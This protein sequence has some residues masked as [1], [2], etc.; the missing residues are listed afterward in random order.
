MSR[1]ATALLVASRLFAAPFQDART[2]E[3]AGPVRARV[4]SE[5]ARDLYQQTE[6]QSSLN[7][8]LPLGKKDAGGFLLIG[9]DYF[10]L[11]DYKKSTDAFDRALALGNGSQQLYVWA[12]RAYG[13]RAE[14]SGPFTA[15]GLA[16]RARKYFEAA[17]QMDIL[18]K[19][20]SGD[21]FDYYMG[22]PGFLGGGLNKAQELARR[23]A[24]AD[25]AEGQHL[26]AA[27]SDKS[28]EYDAEEQH[29]RSAIQLAPKQAGRVMELARFLAQRGRAKESD[30]LFD[31]A[32]RMAPQSHSILFYR[33]LA[34]IEGNRNLSDARAL[35]RAYLR[36]PLTPDD[37]PRQ[38]AQELLAKTH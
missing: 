6:Y 2:T 33:A 35:L 27:L 20:A 32:E 13:R 16:S 34:Y 26:L 9:Q 24:A 3:P 18:N 23:V 22:A 31:Q 10:M 7:L 28:K 8:L 4:E 15:P 30:A 19:E 29:L 21:L 17:V 36:A 37:P 11:G 5:R 12:G 25:P 14:T 1:L 38:R